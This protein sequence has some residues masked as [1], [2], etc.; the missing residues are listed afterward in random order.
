MRLFHIDIRD[1]PIYRYINWY[2]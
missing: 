2:A 1:R